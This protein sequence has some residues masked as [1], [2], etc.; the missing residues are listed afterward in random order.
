MPN[1][2]IIPSCYTFKCFIDFKAAGYFK[3][4]E[5]GTKTSIYANL[6]I[7]CD[8][9]IRR[10]LHKKI[11]SQDRKTGQTGTLTLHKQITKS[12]QIATKMQGW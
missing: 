6:Y 7:H 1:S 12:T 5:H 9:N 2:F 3:T 4:K 8:L 11:I 10:H